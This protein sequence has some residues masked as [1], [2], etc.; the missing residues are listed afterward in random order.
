M[1]RQTPAPEGAPS[2]GRTA[3]A[4]SR[5]RGFAA[6]GA[7]RMSV[8]ALF[9]LRGLVLA[10]I[11]G[12]EIFGIWALFRV[13]M[14]Y[15]GS[16]GLGVLRGLEVEASAPR[17]APGMDP[18]AAR[19]ASAGTTLGFL[20]VVFVALS[21]LA[22]LAAG[23]R[24]GDWLA[25]ALAGVAGG[26][27]F[28]RLWHYGI[29]YL[30][31]TSDLWRLAVYELINAGLQVGLVVTLAFV[32]GLY[33]ALLGFVLAN[34]T[35]IPLLLGRVP[36]RPSLSLARLRSL[37]GTGFPLGLSFFLL[38]SLATID[39]VV[40]AAF[41]GAEPLGYYAFAV[42]LSSLG[43]A[44]AFILRTLVFP[45]VYRDAQARGALLA[46]GSHLRVT[47][48]PFAWVFSPLLGV[49]ALALDPAVRY[50]VPEYQDAVPA[51]RLFLFTGVV[52]GLANLAT[53]G[54]VAANRQWLLPFLT[55]G[56]LVLNLGLAV[57]ALA[58]GLGLEGLAAA[59]LLGRTV[60]AS[61][62]VVAAALG[63]GMAD[64][65][66]VLARTLLPLV[67][68]SVAVGT[69]GHLMPLESG[70]DALAAFTVYAL[71]LLPLVP[72]GWLA[73]RALRQ[74]A[75]SEARKG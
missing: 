11:L 14:R 25:P 32:W 2:G 35:T 19:T 62:I 56:A 21:L 71:A 58:G 67:W 47:L 50:L 60:Y 68:C 36:M 69:L 48:A 9:G 72:F 13:V 15:C 26:L 73:L 33:G 63:S 6:Y 57:G 40:V 10:A 37:L 27:V 8:E 29:T 45:E 59:M 54:V 61:A 42:S 24:P 51:A 39:R 44:L 7:S 75:R 5:L 17:A 52:A 49:L 20:L 4:R 16:A 43:T 53:L 12:P 70:T 66:A 74:S 65:P 1:D 3:A 41:G 31:A 23:L 38:T 30:R 18:D 22:A 46:T 34:A 55:G 28:D 64:W